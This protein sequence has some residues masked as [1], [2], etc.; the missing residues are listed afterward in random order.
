MGADRTPGPLI[1]E[2]QDATVVVPPGCSVSRD[3]SAN[4]IIEIA[5]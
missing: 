5:G 1:V 3:S 4:L 2:E